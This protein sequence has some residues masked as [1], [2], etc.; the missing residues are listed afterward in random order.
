MEEGEILAWLLV[1]VSALALGY[2]AAS[3]ARRLLFRGPRRLLESGLR[4][5][6]ENDLS[7]A[8]RDFA[9]ARERAVA[10]GDLP[11]TAAA[12]RG[13]AE[14]RAQD[15]DELG[16]AAAQAAADDAARQVAR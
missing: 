14:V 15:G 11:A 6:S 13:L 12:W 9:K 3:V 4:H 16:A 2:A 8:A 5:L 7:A 10:R 1:S